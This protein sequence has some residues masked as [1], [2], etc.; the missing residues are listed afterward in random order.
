[1]PAAASRKRAR[2][3][4]ASRR[5]ARVPQGAARSSHVFTRT[6]KA[7]YATYGA[8]AWNNSANQLLSSAVI[9]GTGI[10]RFTLAD[11]PGYQDFTELYEQF[12]ITKVQLRFLPIYG[13]DVEVASPERLIPFAIAANTSALDIPTSAFNFDEILQ[14]QGAK[15]TNSQRMFTMSVKPRAY[16]TNDGALASSSVSPWLNTNGNGANVSH[17]GFKWG[18]ETTSPTAYSGYSVYATYT[19]ECRNPK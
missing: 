18:W 7:V 1:M 15:V 14:E 10:Y 8:G 3:E 11:L 9:A 17:F 2:T 4:S 6:T 16:A 13:T 12:K 19:I 5:K